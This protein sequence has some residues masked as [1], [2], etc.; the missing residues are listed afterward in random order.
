[1][2]QKETLRQKALAQDGIEQ[3]RVLRADSVSKFYGPGKENQLPQDDIDRRA[4]AGELVIEPFT[5]EWGQG[6]VVA[7][8]M[9]SSENY[10]GTNCVACHITPEGEVLG[11]IRLE[12][13]MNHVNSMIN[14]Q[15]MFAIGIM[16]S[17]AFIGFLITM[18]LIRKIIVR[19]IQKISRFMSNVSA[20]KDLS[21]RLEQKQK[22]EMGLLSQSIDSFMD[23]VSDSLERVQ[24]TSH[25]LADSASKLTNVAQSTDEA[26]DNQ[27]VE[28]LSLIHI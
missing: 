27:Q 23:T 25:S 17:I 6:M 10:R 18:G 9:K 7:L 24:D 21:Q 15:A 19:P 26:A 3:V 8:P 12:Y 5:A 4:L 2:V 22:D 16:S 14:K 11:A 1:M 13:N 28:T 20:S